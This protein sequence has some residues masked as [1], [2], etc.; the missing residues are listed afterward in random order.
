MR[1]LIGMVAIIVCA[2]SVSAAGLVAFD[3][4]R[5]QK[6]DRLVS[7]LKRLEELNLTP[8]VLVDSAAVWLE[9]RGYLDAAVERKGDR[10]VITAGR[11]YWL[12][13]LVVGVADSTYRTGVNRVF[14]R[15]ELTRAMDNLLGDYYR[16]GYYY[17]RATITALERR[18][19]RV[20]VFMALNPG[21]LVRFESNRFSG[22]TFSRAET[23]ERYLP[24]T[25][26]DN[27]TEI[28]LRRTEAAAAAIEH[29]ILQP[30]VRVL[31]R[32]GY[33]TADLQ[34]DFAE[35]RRF[36]LAGGGGYAPNDATGL[37]WHLDLSLRNL[38]GGGR[39][40]Q[41]F[42]ERRE[43]G[44]RQLRLH[45]SQPVFVLGVGRLF[46]EAATRDYRDDFYEFSLQ[47]GFDNRLTASTTGGL[48][49]GF[50]RVEP[51]GNGSGYSR[52]MIGFSLTDSALDN[53]L[54]PTAGHTLDW[55]IEYVNRRYQ[56]NAGPDGP[57]GS[58]HNET[59]V[60]AKTGW[61]RRLAGPL[62]GHLAVSYRGLETSEDL[63]PIS[64]LM[65]V[66][67][68]G[69]IRGYRNEQFAARR[70]AYG[71]LESRLVFSQGY[72][73]A[74]YDAAYINHPMAAD[75]AVVTEE[76]YRGGFGVGLHLFQQH[77]A[78]TLSVGWGRDTEPDEPRLAIQLV[79]HL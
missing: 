76:F 56:D 21:P 73:F 61:Y 53:R 46:G 52:L 67:G 66:G 42:S 22:L 63:P 3:G 41:L 38:L 4:D 19:G 57:P 1:L 35:R 11:Q 48:R 78:I 27:L 8:G 12:H 49:L 16:E 77:R 31:P 60:N 45:Y 9:R 74:F 75:E 62:V 37:V 50:K 32:P 71:T 43:R 33:T 36:S 30:P 54:N 58:V 72:L 68:P 24:L 17:A 55:S 20:N 28:N 65:L 25:P 69:T 70:T 51:A 44:R 39:Q 14:T 2:G 13:E 64:E 7:H 59:R 6:A 79:S 29:L 34:F 15:A 5:P 26:G 23:V 10:L 47:A 40:V 18:D